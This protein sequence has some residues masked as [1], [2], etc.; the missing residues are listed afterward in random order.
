MLHARAISDDDRD[1][2]VT[3]DWREYISI[4]PRIIAGKP[5]VKGTR[6]GVEFLLEL[7]ASGWT[8]EMV[9]EGFPHLTTEGLRAVFAYGAECIAEMAPAAEVAHAR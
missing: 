3:M 9:F 4:D 2:G 8:E 7:F 5:A 6:L 1:R